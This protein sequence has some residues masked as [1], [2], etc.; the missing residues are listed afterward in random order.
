MDLG[1]VQA[2]YFLKLPTLASL[3]PDLLVS[4]TSATATASGVASAAGASLSVSTDDGERTTT[5][6][7]ITLVSRQRG[8]IRTKLQSL[9]TPIADRSLITA[10]APPRLRL[11]TTSVPELPTPSRCPL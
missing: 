7:T 3:L 8:G 10:G 5:A 9:L 1:D 6:S 4:S 2:L 11:G